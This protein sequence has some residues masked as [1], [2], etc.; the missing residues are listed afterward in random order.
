VIS[1]TTP[2]WDSSPLSERDMRQKV[3]RCL[4]SLDAISVENPVG[5]GTP[6]VNYVEGWIELKW[7]RSWPKRAETPVTLD[8]ELTTEQRA[9]ARRRTKRGGRAWVMLQCRKEWLLFRGDV[10]ACFLGTATRAELYRHATIWWQDGLDTNGL[11]GALNA[12]EL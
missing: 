2:T 6:D 3:V 11:T 1:A 4:R 10:A 12:T 9:W 7:L 5:P 8:H